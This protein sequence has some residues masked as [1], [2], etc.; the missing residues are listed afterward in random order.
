[1]CNFICNMNNSDN[2]LKA[3]DEKKAHLEDSLHEK[4][5]RVWMAR[6]EHFSWLRKVTD[7]NKKIVAIDLAIDLFTKFLSEIDLSKYVLLLVSDNLSIKDDLFQKS[8]SLYLNEKKECAIYLIENY[9]CI[10]KKVILQCI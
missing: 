5:N 6:K 9:L 8:E 1:M 4:D 7:I 2:I 10:K 3:L